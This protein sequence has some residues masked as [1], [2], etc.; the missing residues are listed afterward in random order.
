MGDRIY[1][2]CSADYD[3]GDCLEVERV[4]IPTN[5]GI[6]ADG[7][8]N[9]IETGDQFY[10]VDDGKGVEGDVDACGN[11]MEGVPYIK[12]SLVENGAA[13]IWN[14]D[15]AGDELTTGSLTGDMTVTNAGGGYNNST[16]GTLTGVEIHQQHGRQGCQSHC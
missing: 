2:P 11:D 8:I 5:E 12:I 14:T 15:K 6:S 1:L 7:G 13:I 10:V 3:I 16:A 9:V 4:K